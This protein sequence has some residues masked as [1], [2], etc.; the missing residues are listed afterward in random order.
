MNI[1]H[2]SEDGIL[3]IVVLG[4]MGADD[5]NVSSSTK[6]IGIAVDELLQE[7]ELKKYLAQTN[8]KP[9]PT[10]VPE[11]WMDSEIVKGIMGH[12]D[13]ADL[14]IVNITPFDGIEGSASPNVFY[15][16]GLLHALGM[17]VICINQ[18]GFEPP[19]YI[20][21]NRILE[22]TS[23]E[24]ENIKEAL[25]SSLTNFLNPADYTDFADN[26]I[27]QFYGLPIVDISAA[28]GLATGY[29]ENFLSR[30][31]KQNGFLFKNNDKVERLIVVRPENV[32][33]DV[34]LD[35]RKM[36]KILTDNGYTLHK[37]VTLSNTDDPFRNMNVDLVGNIVVDLPTTFYTLKSSP[38][39]LSLRERLDRQI[40]FNAPP[41]PKRDL[42]LRQL[43][44]RLL[45][46]VKYVL[47]YHIQK[48]TGHVYQELVDFS[49]I[50]QL[51]EIL[52]KY[53][54]K[55]DS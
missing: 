12:V 8:T 9:E 5:K 2:Y 7:D 29:Y 52:K 30:M 39:L 18:K 25:R 35:K 14:V 24:I 26:R 43:S 50:E 54:V 41:N 37:K 20:K 11:N 51:P 48:N 6:Q 10:K 28:V 38:R 1:N 45:D 17:P 13:T 36:E 40:S 27:T 44:E 53:G 32:L 16:I 23:F 19:F 46:R 21:T 47:Q 3:E 49:T 4:P 42:A 55:P 15:E 33:S 34:E 31:I 22:V